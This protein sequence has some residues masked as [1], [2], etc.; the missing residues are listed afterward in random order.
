MKQNRTLEARWVANAAAYGIADQGQ[1]LNS[2][3]TDM[4]NVSWVCPTIHPDLSIARRGHAGAL[5]PVPRRGRDSAG[6]RDDAPCRDAR[7]ADG[8]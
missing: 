7:G 6:G 5:D 1:D 2:G 3:S 8:L 4:G